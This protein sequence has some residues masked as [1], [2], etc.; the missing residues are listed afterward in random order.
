MTA[1]KTIISKYSDI[2]NTLENSFQTNM[3]TEDIYALVKM[4]LDKMPSWTINN[5]NLD[6]TGSMSY[7]YSYPNQKLSVMIPIQDT[8]T[9][10]K[11]I[12]DGIQA[13]KTF[14]ELTTVPQT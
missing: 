1:S 4:Q 8:V 12:I 3:E 2:L 7:T 9:N 5:V 6:G 10:A 11:T 13:G 14:G